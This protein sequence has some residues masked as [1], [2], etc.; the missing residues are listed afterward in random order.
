MHSIFQWRKRRRKSQSTTEEETS[1]WT[2]KEN[3]YL[4]RLKYILQELLKTR[5][6]SYGAMHLLVIDTDLEPESLLDEDDVGLALQLLSEDLNFLTIFT[7]RPAYFEDYVETMYEETGL[8]VS[9]EGKDSQRKMDANVVLD[10]EQQGGFWKLELTE[11]SIYLPIYKKTWETVENLDI[12]IPIGYNTVIVKG[13][14]EKERVC[15][16]F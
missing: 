11:P 3:P 16:H 8:L 6:M 7:G 12:C 2:R 9:L 5:E 15:E 10:F 14:Q 1:A 13:N 4:P